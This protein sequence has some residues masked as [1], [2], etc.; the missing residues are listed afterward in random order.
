MKPNILILG[1]GL[2]GARHI[3]EVQSHPQVALAGVVDPDPS[4]HAPDYPGFTTLDAVDIPVDAVILA[5]PTETHRPLGVA[6][7]ARGWAIL[8]E[9][10][11]AGSLRDADTLIEACAAGN[12]PLLV[13]HHRRHH[14]A[15]QALRDEVARGRIGRVLGLSAI[16]SVR[17]PDPYFEVPWRSGAGGSP[18]LINLVHDLDLLRFVFGEIDDLAGYLGSTARDGDRE[19][20]GALS[21]RFASGALG[22]ILFS[23]AAPSPWGFEAGTGENP[24]IA[25]SGADYLHIL[26]TS[27]T[28]SFPSLNRH[29]GA[30]DWSEAQ[31]Q[32]PGTPP[33]AA[34]LAAQLSHLV[35]VITKGAAPLC[36][37]TDGR[38]A[39]ELALQVRALPH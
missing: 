5:T 3:A 9:K 2:I 7:A 37:G 35:D 36:S 26:G 13:G 31:T 29:D 32:H 39:L 27:G 16:W 14:A 4:R 21:L 18:V 38:R 33:P 6:C 15:V 25:T 10:P 20:T 34:P 17:K 19:D 22:T 30:A 8:V 23:D 24:N 28:L 11:I 1:G 12:V